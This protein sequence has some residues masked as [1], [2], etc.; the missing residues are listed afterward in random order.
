[1]KSRM[2]NNQSHFFNLSRVDMQILFIYGK[3]VLQTIET[4]GRM[5]KVLLSILTS[6]PLEI[7]FRKEIID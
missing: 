2:R 1:M 3:Y 7:L 4:L 5:R 6:Q